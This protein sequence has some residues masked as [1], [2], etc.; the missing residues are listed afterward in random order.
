MELF[1][2][3]CLHH[4]LFR[5]HAAL[6]DFLSVTDDSQFKERLVQHDRAAAP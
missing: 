1:L 3:N 5:T 6:T 2:Q 4:P